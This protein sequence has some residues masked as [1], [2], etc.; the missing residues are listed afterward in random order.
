MDHQRLLPGGGRRH[1][2]ERCE[3]QRGPAQPAK[4]G[5]DRVG[6]V[7]P[8]GSGPG[9]GGRPACQSRPR[10]TMGETT[11]QEALERFRSCVLPAAKTCR[12]MSCVLD[13]TACSS[14]PQS[15]TCRLNPYASTTEVP[16]HGRSPLMGGDVQ[17]LA[18]S[19]SSPPRKNT[20]LVSD[21]APAPDCLR[22]RTVRPMLSIPHLHRINDV[23]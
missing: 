17:G 3:L 4:P 15:P 6:S 11:L 22:L 13:P 5:A 1:L 2:L 10:V 12:V 7:P 16:G 14:A 9:A 18:N 20:N 8:G 19:R 23:C 21:P